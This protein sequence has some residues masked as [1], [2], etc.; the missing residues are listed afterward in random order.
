MSLVSLK[1]GAR[2]LLCLFLAGVCAACTGVHNTNGIR[3]TFAVTPRTTPEH[4]HLFLAGSLPETG[5]W[6]PAGI[7]MKHD[8]GKGWTA[9]VVLPQGSHLQYLFTR[10]S[11]LNVQTDSSN[12]DMPQFTLDVLR[13]TLITTPVIMWRD[14]RRSVA[15]IA[16]DSLGQAVETEFR[17]H[18]CYHAG[19]DKAWIDPA[20]NDSGWE[21]ADPELVAG[22]LPNDGWP[23][24]GWFRL[25]VVVDT[26][27]NG[28]PLAI[29]IRQMGASEVYIDGKLAYTYGRVGHDEKDEERHEDRN[30]RPLIFSPK[31]VHVIAVRYSSFSVERY[32]R[33]TYPA[34]FSNIGF[35]MAF[36]DLTTEI[37]HQADIAKKNAVSR[38]ILFCIPCALAIMHLFLFVFY[39]PLK[40]NLYN[41]AWLTGLG[42][43][44]F[45][46]NSSD[47]S[48]VL[49]WMQIMSPVICSTAI[50][51][52]LTAYGVSYRVIPRRLYLYLLIAA[53][54]MLWET[55]IS[56]VLHGSV[57]SIFV[58]VV[59]IDMMICYIPRRS[60]S[61]I[62]TPDRVGAWIVGVATWLLGF[63]II[64]DILVANDLI[65]PFRSYPGGVYIYGALALS[66]AVSVNLSRRFAGI[67]K[68]LERQ[69][70][71]VKELSAE[72]LQRERLVREQE[73]ARVQ[74]EA[75]NTRKTE[76]LEDARRLQLSMLPKTLPELPH[77]EIA[78]Y[79]KT[80]TEVGGDY[81]DFHVAEDGTL[82]IAVGDATGH[83]AR[84]GTLVAVTKGL[85]PEMVR[86]ERIPEALHRYSVA[87]KRMNLG[88]L[89]MSLTLV[90]IKDHT[91]TVSAA[92][93][94]PVLIYRSRENAVQTISVKGM[95]LGQFVDFPYGEQE[96][97]LF[98]GD[99][100][101]LM[102]D[103]L[104]E[105]FN[106][107]RE[108]F[109]YMRVRDVLVD[110]GS[111]SPRGLINRLV[112]AGENWAAG[113]PQSDDVTFV[114]IKIRPQ[115][116][117]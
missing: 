110:T 8:T 70:V 97:I 33:Q 28:T 44:I 86:L 38:G 11:W 22:N 81:Y 74:L 60:M 51:G 12:S 50:F 109:D 96:A 21:A 105:M 116:G 19:D 43:M 113:E 10:G 1:H 6:D 49:L 82:T 9:T 108:I 94:P 83:G 111:L 62:A 93:M 46:R 112:Q 34:G 103:G 61:T 42:I 100:I 24:L 63:L 80:A 54:L 66:V 102:T 73:I 95:P 57:M 13:D 68:D 47:A 32:W 65:T 58:I 7:P 69:L 89:Y 4:A 37:A 90:K 77:L 106:P 99:A 84:A 64:Y 115:P 87:I 40:A 41:A 88:Q 39:P 36:G 5:S 14:E 117:P 53:A 107:S 114:A 27:L 75:D 23:G 48:L 25:H 16:A 2:A 104:P 59:F 98:P 72:A 92:G 45:F 18:W 29:W 55:I 17:W 91:M 30:P 3:V 76:E 101:V 26:V 56:R 35:V 78:A 67:T 31:L 79:M 15:R 71:Q 85:F 20:L 52:L